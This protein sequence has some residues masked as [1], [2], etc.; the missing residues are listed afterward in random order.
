MHYNLYLAPS[1]SP[2]RV[3]ATS[4]SSDTF[5]LYWDPP[6]YENQNGVIQYY[7]IR[8]LE[9]ESGLVS[10]YTSYTFSLLLS[11]L[12]PAYTYNCIIAAYTVALGPFSV[13]FNVTTDEEGIVM[14]NAK[15]FKCIWYCNNNFMM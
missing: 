4:V 8:V 5:T 6:P 2:T 3:R 14:H 11:S 12:H 1:S 10:H 9:V 7:S 15:T 13:D